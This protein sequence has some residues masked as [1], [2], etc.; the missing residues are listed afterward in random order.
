[1]TCGSIGIGLCNFSPL[2]SEIHAE[3]SI[4][5]IC[6]MVLPHIW[7]LWWECAMPARS[8][9]FRLLVGVLDT[10]LV[11]VGYHKTALDI[12]STKHQNILGMLCVVLYQ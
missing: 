4:C 3:M 8:G 9:N 1:M 12:L 7:S 2:N 10:F 5:L 11:V 6:A